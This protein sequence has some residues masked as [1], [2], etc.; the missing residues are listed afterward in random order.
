MPLPSTTY[1]KAT[2]TNPS[3]DITDFTLAIDLKRMTSEWWSAVD[4]ADPT[5]GR[6]A[7]ESDESELACSWIDF[8]SSATS[9]ILRVKWS[10]KLTASGTQEL[11]VYPPVSS[12]DSYAAG[13]SYGSNN[14][15]DANWVEYF[16]GGIS[17]GVISGITLS[18]QGGAGLVSSGIF[19]NAFVFDDALLQYM[20]AGGASAGGFSG[21]PVTIMAWSNFDAAGVQPTP[22]CVG[23][24]TGFSDY[25]RLRRDGGNNKPQINFQSSVEDIGT[26]ITLGEW[27]HTSLTVTSSD[28]EAFLNGTGTGTPTAH[29]QTWTE[30]DV[31]SIGARYG[32]GGS[33]THYMSGLV[34]E[35]QVHSVERPNAWIEQEY[36]QTQSNSSFWG[37]WSNQIAATDSTPITVGNSRNTWGV[38]ASMT[39]IPKFIK[40]NDING[41]ILT[42]R[43]WEKRLSGSD[44]EKGLMEVLIAGKFAQKAIENQPPVIYQGMNPTTRKIIGTSGA[45]LNPYLIEINDPDKILGA[46][47]VSVGTTSGLP[48]GLSVI[49]LSV[50]SPI[51]FFAISGIPTAS[52]TGTAN[53]VFQDGNSGQVTAM[54][55]YAIGG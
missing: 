26:G 35:C 14:A 16:P 10:G 7:K 44:R 42:N 8:D 47:S 9:G 3:A 54:I 25:I 24:D 33:V 48:N 32:N 13:A 19:G 52:G 49:K 28:I 4:T 50:D 41:V 21:Y 22:F 46:D 51:E 43:G 30:L 45:E 37:D 39:D 55:S 27:A 40:G 12:N 5:K 1:D 18:E 2:L 36:T 34:G 38:T 11:R 6:A 17:T 31:Y 20:F 29:T 53:V 15:Y 23:G